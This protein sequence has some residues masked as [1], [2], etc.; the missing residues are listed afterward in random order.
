MNK[1]VKVLGIIVAVILVFL[2]AVLS[3]I[4]RKPF[5][6]TKHYAEWQGN[7]GTLDFAPSTET[8]Q[9]G[10]AKVNITPDKA[11]PMAGY[12]DRWG[13]HFE[14]VHDSLYVRAIS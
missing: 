14:G 9:I 5:T 13:A 10:W 4:D 6:E 3:K 1:L 11:I 2:I 8:F 7:L 12:G